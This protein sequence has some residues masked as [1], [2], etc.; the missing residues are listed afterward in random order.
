MVIESFILHNIG[1]QKGKEIEIYIVFIWII[2]EIL[3]VNRSADK[4]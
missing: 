2:L 4:N 3:G 1:D